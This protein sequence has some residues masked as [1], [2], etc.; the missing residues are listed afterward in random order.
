MFQWQGKDFCSLFC[1]NE[2]VKENIPDPEKYDIHHKRPVSKGGH[3]GQINGIPNKIAVPVKKHQAW[4]QLFYNSDP[5]TIAQTINEIWL[6][7][8]YEFVC[9]KRLADR[10][11]PPNFGHL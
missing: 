7:P 6:D 11:I 10:V 9:R 8:E 3:D 2:W 4:H 5:E 1:R